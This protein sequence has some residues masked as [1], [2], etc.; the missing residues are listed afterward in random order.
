[1]Y[2]LTRWAKPRAN[3]EPAPIKTVTRYEYDPRLRAY[4]LR[5]TLLGHFKNENDIREDTSD[6]LPNE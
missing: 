4:L 6:E 2:R 3:P 5:D 1:M